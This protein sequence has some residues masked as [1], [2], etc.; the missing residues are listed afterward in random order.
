M[1]TRRHGQE[2]TVAPPPPSG[3][4]VKCF[5][6][7]VVTPKC[8]VNKVFMHY[9]HNLSAASGGFAPRFPLKLHPGPLRDI[10][11]QAPNLPTP[12]KNLVGAHCGE[13]L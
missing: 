10:C 1:G 13:T 9:F 5:C 6:A 2:G 12:G 11:P 3:N 4:F 8:S 7:P